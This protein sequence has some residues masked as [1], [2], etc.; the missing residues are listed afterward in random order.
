M[1]QAVIWDMD[2]TLVDS[3]HMW[4]DVGTRLL[5]SL[6]VTP[7]ENLAQKLFAMSMKEGVLYLKET[8]HLQISEDEIANRME[9]IVIAFYENEVTIKGSVIDCLEVL[10]KKGIKMAL[11][12]ATNK[13]PAQ[14]A[15]KRCGLESY[16]TVFYTCEE[17]GAD[18][19]K[20]DIYQLCSKELAVPAAH[21]LVLEDAVHSLETAKQA[22][23]YTAG[24]YDAQS[25]SMQ[26]KIRQISNV[27]IDEQL[28]YEK[29]VQWMDTL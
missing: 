26:K 21:T 12:T 1:I 2:G 19:T 28:Q 22:V 9:E 8:Y 25:S 5:H 20:P 7:E 15:L 4:R 17:A 6:Q 13:M 23:Y 10:K 14:K 24:V 3:M 11:A 27:Y 18:K 29:I 16:F